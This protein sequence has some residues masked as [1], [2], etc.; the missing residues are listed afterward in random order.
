MHRFDDGVQG[1]VHFATGIGKE[2]VDTRNGHQGDLDAA[3]AI[4]RQHIVLD[5]EHAQFL[6]QIG[7]GRDV[8]SVVMVYGA[9]HFAHFPQLRFDAVQVGTRADGIR[10]GFAQFALAFMG[11]QFQ[12]F[13]EF[14]ALENIF[15]F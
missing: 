8:H 1:R 4:F 3:Q 12:Y 13:V 10:S 6:L 2:V 9:P 14:Q 5:F 7:V 15:R 11:D